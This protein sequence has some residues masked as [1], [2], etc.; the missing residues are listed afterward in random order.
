MQFNRLH[1]R[2]VRSA[3]TATSSAAD[4]GSEQEL[5]A[6]QAGTFH[7]AFHNPIRHTRME[8]LCVQQ[9]HIHAPPTAHPTILFNTHGWKL[10]VCN[11]RTFTLLLQHIPQ[12]YSTHSDGS[13]VCATSAHSRSSY[14]TPHN[15][16]TLGWKP[17][18]C[19]KRTFMLLLQHIPQS[20]STHSDGSSVCAT[21]AH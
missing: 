1:A 19:N 4:T 16:K 18:V 15:P 3:A 11:K 6:M 2:I 17:S 9:T 8:A 10:S 14:S 12:S 20:Y 21:N 7:L 5:R 13:R